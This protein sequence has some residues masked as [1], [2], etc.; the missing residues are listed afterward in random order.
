MLYW[1]IFEPLLRM[2]WVKTNGDFWKLHLG[3]LD[4]NF[5]LGRVWQVLLRVLDNIVRGVNQSFSRSLDL[6][7][8]NKTYQKY[9]GARTVATYHE[10]APYYTSQGVSKQVDRFHI[11][12]N[13][14][15]NLKLCLSG[16]CCIIKFTANPIVYVLIYCGSEFWYWNLDVTLDDNYKN[17]PV[18]ITAVKLAKL[19]HV[20]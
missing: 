9:S 3:A 16:M 19:G 6:P 10:A 11:F 13:N 2:H 20:R 5:E 12:L 4:I 15:L 18:S 8:S 1:Q 14:L 7:N 17:L